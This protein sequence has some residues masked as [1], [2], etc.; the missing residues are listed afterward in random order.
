[1]YYDYNIKLS[2]ISLTKEF[3]YIFFVDDLIYNIHQ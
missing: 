1:M 2:K 3:F